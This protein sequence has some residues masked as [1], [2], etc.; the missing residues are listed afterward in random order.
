MF[1]CNNELNLFVQ[2][3]PAIY[4]PPFHFPSPKIIGYPWG[5][6]GADSKLSKLS[7]PQALQR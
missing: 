7:A 2:T 6:E 4:P 3:I 1:F 5:Q